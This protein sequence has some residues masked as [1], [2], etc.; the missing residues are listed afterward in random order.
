MAWLPAAKRGQTGT[1]VADGTPDGVVTEIER[2]LTTFGVP[3]RLRDI[4]VPQESLSEATDHAMDDW[5][6][7]G[8]PRVPERGDIVQ[9]LENAW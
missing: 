8:A 1:R 7:T 5:A 2:L 6:I 9:L 4:G 3:R